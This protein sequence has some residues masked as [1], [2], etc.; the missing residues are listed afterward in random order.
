MMR[1]NTLVYNL[2]FLTAFLRIYIFVVINREVLLYTA[3]INFGLLNF[4]N[5]IPSTGILSLAVSA[6]GSE[7]V[8]AQ[9][10]KKVC[11]YTTLFSRST[12]FPDGGRGSGS[13]AD[14]LH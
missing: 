13:G 1:K 2:F 14:L 4:N 8:G 7:A 9:H 3:K 5:Y 12:S 10:R 6:A 11:T